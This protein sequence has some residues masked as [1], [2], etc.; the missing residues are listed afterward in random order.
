M[1][2]SGISVTVACLATSQEEWFNSTFPLKILNS[3]PSKEALSF[4]KKHL[5]GFIVPGSC[6]HYIGVMSGDLLFGVLGFSNPSYGNYDIFLKA[7]TTPSEYTRATE[8]LLYVLRT[9]EVKNM[10][11]KKFCREI[12]TIYSVCFSSHEVISRYR[13]HGELV[14]KKV[15]RSNKF[16]ADEKIK[17]KANNYVNNAIKNGELI[18]QPCEICGIND[19]VE[20]HHKDYNKPKDINWLCIKHHNEKDG[21]DETCYKIEGYDLGYIF[22]AG[23]IISLKEAKSR[24]IQKWKN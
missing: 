11:E 10:L 9:N 15:I 21:E 6:N 1:I 7:D 5:K 4:R 13:K 17:R 8:L 3:L 22:K 14:T 24:F 20:A 23:S 12:N 18:K 19:Y 2:K 16:S